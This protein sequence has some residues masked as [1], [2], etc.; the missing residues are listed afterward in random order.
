MGILKDLIAVFKKRQKKAHQ[1][2]FFVDSINQL[3]EFLSTKIDNSNNAHVVTV[4]IKNF[5]SLNGNEKKKKL[6]ESYLYVEKYLTD[7]DRKFTLSKK[8]LRMLIKVEFAPLLAIPDFALIFEDEQTQEFELS[9]LFLLHILDGL[10]DFLGDKGSDKL[11]EVKNYLETIPNAFPG[12]NPLNEKSFNPSDLGDWVHFLRRLSFFT[13]DLLKEK[14]GEDSAL[15]RFDTAYESISKKYI[16]LDSFQIIITFL[17]EQLMDE[18][19]INTLSKHQIEKLLLKKADHFEQITKDL[20]EKNQELEKTQKLLIEA[21]NKAEEATRSKAMFL[22]NM[23]HEIRTPMNAVI[24]MTEILKDTNPTKEQQLYIDTIHKSGYDLVHIINDILDYSKIES[25]KMELEKK[26]LNIHDFASDVVNLLMLKAEE[27]NIDLIYYVDESIPPL[28]EADPTRLKQILVNLIGNA[29]K[30]TNSGEVVY[31]ISLNELSKDHAVLLFE[32]SDTG[33]GIPE[34]KLSNIF[35]SFSQVDVS[36]T[37]NYGGTGLGLAI[38]KSLIDLMGGDISVSSELNKGSVF[39]FTLKVPYNQSKKKAKVPDEF[40][41]KTVLIAD[42]NNT[43]RNFLSLKLSNWGF[44]VYSFNSLNELVANFGNFSSVDIILIEEFLITSEDET[45]LKSFYTHISSKEIPIVRIVPFGFIA[46][47]LNPQNHILTVNKPLRRSD[48]INIIFKAFTEANP[49]SEIKTLP[50]LHKPKNIKIL[51]AEDNFTNQVVAKGLLTKIGYSLD[52]ANN[53]EEVLKKINVEYY[54]LILMDVQM[55]ILDGIKTTQKIR[56]NVYKD[57][58]PIIIA[59]TANASEED[60]QLCIFSGMNDYLSKPVR[61][62]EII[63]KLEKW[64]P[65]K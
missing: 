16:N 31:K 12:N 43:Q 5:L 40:K 46:E 1:E 7:I 8:E 42:Q 4:F 59:M 24:G 22:A 41:G 32:I 26:E 44:H 35:D 10:F 30:F 64:F 53:G 62:N 38:T 50:E 60:K 23:S 65:D 20:S 55:P 36:T 61:K 14:L 45:L 58:Q 52:I 63:K 34:N 27:K 9:R 2:Q 17:P 29:I 39:T 33:I 3:F 57:G 18:G 49:S 25:G 15:K 37:R 48:L 21:K 28:V 11:Q 54:D 19:R 13:Y 56:Q 51:L 47:K 6:S